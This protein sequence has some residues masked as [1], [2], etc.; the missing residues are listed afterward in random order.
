MKLFVENNASKFPLTIG[1]DN[2]ATPSGYIDETTIEG[3]GNNTHLIQYIDYNNF[4]D[5]VLELMLAKDTVNT[6]PDMAT[7]FGSCTPAEQ[8][9]CCEFQLM[10]YAVRLNFFTDEQDKLNWEKLVMLTEGSPYGSLSGRSK[11]YQ[12]LRIKVSDYVRR[13][14][15]FP[16]DYISNLSYAQQFLKD[17]HLLKEYYIASNDIEFGQFLK[18]E[19]LYLNNGFNSKVYWIQELEDELLEILNSY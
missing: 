16:N 18:S 6:P 9:V 2:D 19:G 17:T 1:Q 4:R 13:E 11:I 3:V 5:W 7:A 8:K 15:W 14:V 10:P 12:D